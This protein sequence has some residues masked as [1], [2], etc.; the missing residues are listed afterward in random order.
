MASRYRSNPARVGRQ[1]IAH[2]D[3]TWRRRDT[4]GGGRLGWAWLIA[5]ACP[6][7]RLGARE[8]LEVWSGR[9]ELFHQRAE[10]LR[11]PTMALGVRRDDLRHARLGVRRTGAARG[12]EEQLGVRLVI[13]PEG[14]A[15]LRP[16]EARF[17][18]KAPRANDVDGV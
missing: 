13:V 10:R 8:E 15:R 4:A 16:H 5:P 1:H 12:H 14:A 17:I 6:A 11:L 9:I 2:A 18:G 7:T 3:R